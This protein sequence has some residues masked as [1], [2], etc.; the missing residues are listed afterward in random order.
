MARTEGQNPRLGIADAEVMLDAITDR[1]ILKLDS[2]GQVDHWSAGASAVFGYS[3]G[4]VCGHAVAMLHSADDRAANS[5]EKELIDARSADHI[6][7]EGWRVR[8][9][10]HHFRAR[11][12]IK[13]I[14]DGNGDVTGFVEVIRDPAA[15]QKRAHPLFFDLLEAAPDAMVIVGPDGRITLGNAQTDRLFGYSRDELVGSE[16]EMLLPERF[17]DRHLQHRR[18]Y[19]AQ[20]LLRPMGGGLELFGLRHDGTEFP[21]DISLGPLQIDNTLYVSAS[22]RDVTERR[23]QEHRLRR[24]HQELVEAKQALERLARMDTLTG[25]VNH[26]ETISRLEAALQNRRTPGSHLGVLF[27]DTDNFKHV[28]DTW[29]HNV[30]DAVLSTIAARIS[31]CV[32]EGD[33]VGRIG[34]DEMLVLLPGVHSIEEV[35]AIANKIRCRAAEPIH[36]AGKTVRA[37]LSIGATLAFPGESVSEMTTRADAAMYAAKQAGRDTVRSV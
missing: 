35:V 6:E 24:Q 22:I 37:T 29:G 36:H 21:V 18:D 14:R 32:R 5:P 30:G 17:R 34:G 9:G 8:K 28:N 10:G 11:V 20:P 27:C 12:L 1:A 2:T 7:F 31:D 15:D 3:A 16:L 25:L 33:T 19:F 13:T 26:A 23:E 4:E